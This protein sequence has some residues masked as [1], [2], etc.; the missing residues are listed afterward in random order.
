[1]R[2]GSQRDVWQRLKAAA[3]LNLQANTVGFRHGAWVESNRVLWD[4]TGLELPLE[5][6][7][8][9]GSKVSSVYNVV[10]V[11]YLLPCYLLL[12]GF[13]TESLFIT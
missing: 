7:P 9:G 11:P 3:E 4:Q 12:N 1:M 6:L 13:T 2:D 10:K 5:F 8:L